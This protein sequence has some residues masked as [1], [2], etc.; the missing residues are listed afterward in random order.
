MPQSQLT[1]LSNFLRSMGGETRPCSIEQANCEFASTVLS[2]FR[3]GKLQKGDTRSGLIVGNVA[4]YFE[5]LK[6]EA[7]S[8]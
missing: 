2:C 7:L 3:S 8:I 5:V 6:A 1:L 4:L